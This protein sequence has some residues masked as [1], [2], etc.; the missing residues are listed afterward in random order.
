MSKWLY[1]NQHGQQW[2][3]EVRDNE[4]DKL[5]GPFASYGEAREYVERQ[6]SEQE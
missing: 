3:R 2:V 4:P 5:H 6:K 1:E